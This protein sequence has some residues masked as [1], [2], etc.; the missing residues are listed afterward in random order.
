MLG[1]VAIPLAEQTS[2]ISPVLVLAAFAVLIAILTGLLATFMSHRMSGKSYGLEGVVNRAKKEQEESEV[3]FR[4]LM[5]QSPLA[6][7]IYTPEGK[8][9]QVNDAWLRLWGFDEEEVPK[10]LANYNVLTDNQI[11]DLGIAHLIKRAFDGEP[12][13]LPTIQYVGTRTTQDIGLKNIVAKSPWIQ[14]HLFPIKNANQEV[15]F[16]V[17]THMDFSEHKKTEGEVQKLRN[18]YAHIARVSAMGELAA[19]LA[20]ELKQ[21]L[22]AIRSNAQAAQRFL[23]TE[24]PNFDEL[25]EILK[26]IIK[27]NRRADDVIGKIRKWMQ[28]GELQFSRIDINE[29]IRDIRP[30]INSYETGKGISLKFELD[31]SIPK[32]SADR[33][34]LQQVI[35]NLIINS[36]E[37]FMSETQ[38]SGSITVLTNQNNKDNV[39]VSVADNGPGID[40][41]VMPRLFEPFY[42]TKKEGLGMG[43]AISRSII[44]GHGGHLWAENNR[45]R[46]ATV[47][48]TIPVAREDQG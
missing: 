1:S 9:A 14:C 12:V 28:K 16:V 41:T 29:A 47:S 20:H 3:S 24:K 45:T 27:D 4:C 5:E 11:A 33:I 31:S 44:D 48:F 35:L 37:A 17:N 40:G 42:T 26:D 39:T 21:P 32:V 36:T 23:T 46:G 15:E 19:S 13:V 10:V 2:D 34:Q 30:L 43:L 18:E 38:K 8:I 25:H 7:A 6:I 22:A